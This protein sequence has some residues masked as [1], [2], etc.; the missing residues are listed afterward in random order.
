[1]DTRK[2][3][4][5]PAEVLASDIPSTEETPL[6]DAEEVKNSSGTFVEIKPDAP[7]K[8]KER[9]VNCVEFIVAR[10]YKRHKMAGFEHWVKH[11]KKIGKHE[12]KPMKAWLALAEEFW[13]T[14]IA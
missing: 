7:E 13:A 14:P 8:P 1:M 2:K 12:F 6:V 5:P 4:E 10:G 11:T 9:G 3:R